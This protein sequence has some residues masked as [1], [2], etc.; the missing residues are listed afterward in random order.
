MSLDLSSLEN[1]VGQ[2]ERVLYLYNSEP[3]RLYPELKD[4]MRGSVIQAFEYTYELSFK[5]LKRH[6]EA[7]Y[8]DPNAIG[9]A[10]FDSVIRTAFGLDLVCSDV[11]V[12]RRY[13]ENRGITSHTYDRRKAQKVFEC[14]PEFLQEARYV[15]KKLQEK[16]STYGDES[17]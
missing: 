13:R 5:M 2:L 8:A 10:T 16:N 12:W 1:A 14:A 3:V 4:P 6:L 17:S 7:T 11:S 15:L 9:G